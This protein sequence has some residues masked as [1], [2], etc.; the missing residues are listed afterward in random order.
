MN[1]FMMLNSNAVC[2]HGVS[3][4]IMNKK[5]KLRSSLLIQLLKSA[6]INHGK[7]VTVMTCVLLQS[8]GKIGILL[9][10]FHKK[11]NCKCFVKI[12][13]FN[14]SKDNYNLNKP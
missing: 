2:I 7:D 12:G 5:K 9:D 6:C 3:T 4:L 14:N 11:M 1:C 13:L 8:C 10:I